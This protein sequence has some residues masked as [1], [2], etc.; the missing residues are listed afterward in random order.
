MNIRTI[1]AS[2]FTGHRPQIDV[3]IGVSDEKR[4][5]LQ[6]R[7]VFEHFHPDAL[8]IPSFLRLISRW[9]FVLDLFLRSDVGCRHEQ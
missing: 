8:L 5:L 6:H 1:V 4:R 9:N 7:F 3:E 2:N